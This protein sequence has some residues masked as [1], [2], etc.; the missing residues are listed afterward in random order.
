MRRLAVLGAAG[1][2][3]LTA[4]GNADPGAGDK[5]R[6]CDHLDRLSR[7]D[8]FLAFGDHASADDVEVA[9]RALV[10]RAHELVDVAPPEARPAARD[11]ADAAE[12]LDSL[13]AGSAYLP[14]GVDTRAYRARQIAYVDAAQRLERY[15][16]A[17]C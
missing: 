2:L 6:F 4:C 5:P 13:L 10:D 8:P 12:A 1:L 11:Y 17:E 3:A 9:F 16:N 15:L 7:N 14:T